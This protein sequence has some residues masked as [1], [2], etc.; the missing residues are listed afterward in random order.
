[1]SVVFRAPLQPYLLMKFQGEWILEIKLK[2]QLT[3]QSMKVAILA[4]L[5]WLN[6]KKLNVKRRL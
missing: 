2:A 4:P 5:L 6:K 1:M 3:A